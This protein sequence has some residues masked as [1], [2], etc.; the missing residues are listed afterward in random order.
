MIVF[1]DWLHKTI[2][3][4]LLKDDFYSSLSVIVMINRS[5]VVLEC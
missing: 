3:I 2:V 1:C 5:G 4:D